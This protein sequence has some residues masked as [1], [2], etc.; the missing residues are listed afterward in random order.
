LNLLYGVREVFIEQENSYYCKSDSEIPLVSVT[1]L[2]LKSRIPIISLAIP[3]ALSAFTHLWNPIGF[4]AIHGD[5]NTYLLHSMQVLGAEGVLPTGAPHYDHPYFGQIF[6]A[7]V[8]GT[9]G[10]PQILNPVPGDNYS[11][12]TLYLVPRILMGLLAVVDTFLIYKIAD[13]RYNRKVAFIAAVLFAVMPFSWLLRRV[14]L[15]NLL[16]PFLLSSIFFA[17]HLRRPKYESTSGIKNLSTVLVSGIFLGLTIFTKM[18]TFTFIPL[19][20]FLVYT[21]TNR[22]LKALSLWLIP[23]VLI[24]AIWPF[25]AASAGQFDNWYENI[26]EQATERQSEPLVDSL[27]DFLTIDPVLF[28]LGIAGLVFAALR[29]DLFVLLL[30]IPYLIF[31]QLIAFVDVVHLVLLLP[32]FCIGSARMIIETTEYVISKMKF[33]K[34]RIK[35]LPLLAIIVCAIGVFGLVS[36]SM[37]ITTKLNSSYFEAYAIVTGHIDQVLNNVNDT[38]NA[39][40]PTLVGRYWAKAYLWI[41]Q[42]VFDK[43]YS[44]VRDTS[45]RDIAELADSNNKASLV[46]VLDNA[47][48]RQVLRDSVGDDGSSIQPIK[49]LYDKTHPLATLEGSSR[50]YDPDKYPYTSM[51]FT[52]DINDIEIRSN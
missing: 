27:K 48:K 42:Y 25:L 51:R 23:V 3:L 8:W 37:I 30:A 33:K 43:Q 45:D 38:A 26:I 6:L 28:S 2:K 21:N 11:I 4:P 31:L 1:R 19:L 9:V 24:P 41:T 7:A 47:L 40:K 18:P 39:D 14:L 32:A 44:F 10:Y 17:V 13:T 15:D 16:I 46:L 22:D 50:T 35:L 36:T 52:R 29:K 20:G 49:S 12:D 34:E 5:E